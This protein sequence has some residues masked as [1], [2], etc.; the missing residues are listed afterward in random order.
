MKLKNKDYYNVASD[1][2]TIRDVKKREI[3]KQNK[4]NYLEIFSNDINECISQL[5][6]KIESLKT[7]YFNVST[8]QG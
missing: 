8:F 2:W 4:L 6:Q 3:A 1:V 7:L 5:K